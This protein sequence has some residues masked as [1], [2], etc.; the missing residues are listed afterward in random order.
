MSESEQ[1]TG[2]SD[3]VY[4]LTSVLYHAGEGRSTTNT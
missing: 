1:K 2:L 3:N 4:N